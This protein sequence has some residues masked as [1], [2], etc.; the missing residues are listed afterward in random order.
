MYQTI[1]ANGGADEAVVRA[2]KVILVA[3]NAKKTDGDE[4][5]VFADK[6]LS[7]HFGRTKSP[8][9]NKAEQMARTIEKKL[10]DMITIEG[11]KINVRRVAL[12]ATT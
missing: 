3:V 6:L 2:E 12:V 7:A 4:A 10:V 8:S 11:D 5:R 9:K 1:S